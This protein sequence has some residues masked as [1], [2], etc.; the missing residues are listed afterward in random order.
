MA[1]LNKLSRD[2]GLRGASRGAFLASAL[3]EL[4]VALARGNAGIFRAGAKVYARI[5]GKD[6]WGGMSAPVAEPVDDAE[7]EDCL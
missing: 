3:R 7:F 5:A 2:S 6:R 4:S 1:F